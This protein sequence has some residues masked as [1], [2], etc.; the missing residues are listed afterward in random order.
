V[1][2]KKQMRRTGIKNQQIGRINV[3]FR[4]YEI[5]MKEID[6]L[7]K[8][9]FNGNQAETLRKLVREALVRRR[10]V[11]EGKDA[12]MSIVKESQ[13]RVIDE[14]LRPLS[15]QLDK[16]R[17]Q[18]RVLTETNHNLSQA[19]TSA[20]LHTS[21]EMTQIYEE[22]K[23]LAEAGKQPANVAEINLQISKLTSLLE[24]LAANSAT[25][26]QNIIALR[27][28]FY[29]FL[30]AYQTGSLEEAH[31]LSRAQWVYF[32]RSVQRRANKLAVEEFRSLDSYEQHRFIESYAQQIFEQVSIVKQSDIEKLSKT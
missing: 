9:E 11:T 31:Q 12:T 10:L 29:V 1:R 15:V 4:P 13:A 7:T 22:M 3:N 8:N 26:L 23:T 18:V 20:T 5:D 27:S 6:S 32:V 19:V 21:S 25:S 30:L 28:L 24:P 14:R 16:L 17:E 2:K